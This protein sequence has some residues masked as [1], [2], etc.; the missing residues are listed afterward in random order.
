MIIS[1]RKTYILKIKETGEE[2]HIFGLSMNSNFY[3]RECK[4]VTTICPQVNGRF[5]HI[6]ISEPP[7]SVYIHINDVYILRIFLV[8]ENGSNFE[9]YIPKDTVFVVE[10][11]TQLRLF[12]E[13]NGCRHDQSFRL[14]GNVNNYFIS[15]IRYFLIKKFSECEYGLDSVTTLY[16]PSE[17][18]CF[19]LSSNVMRR[20]PDILLSRD[21]LALR[22]CYYR[23]N[24]GCRPEASEYIPI[25]EYLKDKEKWW[26]I[27]FDK[28]KSII[29]KF[30]LCLYPLN[31]EIEGLYEC[32]SYLL[33]SLGDKT[34]I[35]DWFEPLPMLMIRAVVIEQTNKMNRLLSQR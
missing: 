24:I 3:Y 8:E 21:D 7:V 35:P 26:N 34:H 10:L 12:L 19:Y 17:S 16:R 27:V 4:E 15:E 14:P 32:Y 2:F 1:M 25:I 11:Y 6:S 13:R 29:I 18:D 5:T 28:L 22:I 30:Q 20:Q 31:H 33:E 23:K 9:I